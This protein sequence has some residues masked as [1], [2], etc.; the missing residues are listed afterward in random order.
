[1][2]GI[3]IFAVPTYRGYT[4]YQ[5][6]FVIGYYTST[7]PLLALHGL[8]TLCVLARNFGPL[9]GRTLIQY[10]QGSAHEIKR[11]FVSIFLDLIS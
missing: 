6:K 11:K 1:M 10:I 4:V 8:Q 7:V 3:R 2:G 5:S 9:P